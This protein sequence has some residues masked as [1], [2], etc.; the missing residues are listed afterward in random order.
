MFSGYLATHR[1]SSVCG[2]KEI[3]ISLGGG[4]EHFEYSVV[5]SRKE[6]VQQIGRE[7][8]TLALKEEELT[9]CHKGPKN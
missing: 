9:T 1:L 8:R 6:V 5:E 3:V 7:L 4:C 2:W